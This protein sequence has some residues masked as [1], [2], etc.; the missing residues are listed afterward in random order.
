MNRHLHSSCLSYRQFI[1]IFFQLE[2]VIK[3]VLHQI[4]CNCI[5][6]LRIGHLWFQVVFHRNNYITICICLLSLD[7]HILWLDLFSLMFVV[8]GVIDKMHQMNNKRAVCWFSSFLLR[9]L[10]FVVT[11]TWS[12]Q[13][14]THIAQLYLK[15]VDI[16]LHT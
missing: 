5:S 2:H 4:G 9:S 16:I 6:L 12:H 15:F 3:Q 7:S 13:D 11:C 1:I 14:I 10:S 8:G